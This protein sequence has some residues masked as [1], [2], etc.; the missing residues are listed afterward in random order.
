MRMATN[1]PN[2]P[3][4][5]VLNQ[6]GLSLIRILEKKSIKLYVLDAFKHKQMDMSQKYKHEAQYLS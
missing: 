1:A 3:L 5:L 4:Y 6:Q 2:L